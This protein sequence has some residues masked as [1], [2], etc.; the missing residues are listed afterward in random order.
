MPEQRSGQAG[1]I[2]NTWGGLPRKDPVREALGSLTSDPRWVPEAILPLGQTCRAGLQG[3]QVW[4]LEGAQLIHRDHLPM[5]EPAERATGMQTQIRPPGPHEPGESSLP[6]WTPPGQGDR[7][8][9]LHP[10]LLNTGVHV[11]H[12]PMHTH[13]THPRAYTLNTCTNTQHKHPRT[14]TIYTEHMRT[15]VCTQP[16]HTCAHIHIHAHTCIR[17]HT[18]THMHNTPPTHI[19]M[20][21]CVHKCIRTHAYMCTHIYTCTQVCTRTHIYSC[22]RAQ[23]CMHTYVH[24]HTYMHTHALTQYT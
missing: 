20:H 12:T 5:G 13:N 4:V 16:M 6:A 7:H 23:T 1:L 15:H 18:C 8:T 9:H 22:T 11:P 19:C 24:I 10:Y 14:H 21:T 2:W 3:A 17:I